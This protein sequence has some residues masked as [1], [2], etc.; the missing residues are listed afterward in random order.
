MNR[1][2]CESL[3]GLKPPYDIEDIVKAYRKKAKLYHPDMGGTAKQFRDI[4]EAKEY[5][6]KYFPT[7]QKSSTQG[8]QYWKTSCDLSQILYK[9]SRLR[10]LEM[11]IK[12]QSFAKIDL[13]SS[14]QKY[15][16]TIKDT[17]NMSHEILERRTKILNCIPTVFG[18]I[19]TT[20]IVEIIMKAV[21]NF[22]SNTVF[23]VGL[24]L[25]FM[26]TAIVW[27]IAKQKR[28]ELQVNIFKLETKLRKVI[29]DRAK[30]MSEYDTRINCLQAEWNKIYAD[31]CGGK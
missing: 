10:Q 30:S 29:A 12:L 23:N 6:L 14:Y 13:D 9:K 27:F 26:C 2:D 15:I 8:G 16:N 22:E 4:T 20:K 1:V 28:D 24:I 17:L 31:L 3:L 18:A 19:S 21:L 11:E 5:L 7:T 25:W